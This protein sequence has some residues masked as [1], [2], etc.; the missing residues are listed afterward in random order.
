MN[1]VVALSGGKDSTAMA[2]RRME[3]EPRNYIYICTPTGREL[4][5]MEAHW[6]RL[7][8]LLGKPLVRITN[9]T[10][11]SWIRERRAL[12]NFRMR[13]CTRVLKIEPMKAFLTATRPCIHYV[14]LR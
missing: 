14:G 6:S 2:L 12:P 11:A 4:P 7:E 1:H 8:G 5:E 13:W 3:V 10:L 9:G